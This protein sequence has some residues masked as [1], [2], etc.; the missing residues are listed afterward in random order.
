MKKKHLIFIV[1]F[2][3]IT[4]IAVVVFYINIFFI[5]DARGSDFLYF[6]HVDVTK[7]L[8]QL[9]G[10]TSSSGEAFKN[11]EYTIDGEDLYITI[12]YVIVSKT[13]HSGRFS[14]K[15][16]DDLSQIKRIYL[17]DGEN[18]EIIWQNDPAVDVP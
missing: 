11:Y 18:K 2:A 6:D 7:N 4:I 14:I 1:C 8:L 13:Y 16:E 9:D 5:G 3:A 15:I 17:D 12:K 10:S